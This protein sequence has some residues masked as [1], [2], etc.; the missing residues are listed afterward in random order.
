M[1]RRILPLDVFS[2]VWVGEHYIIRRCAQQVGAHRVDVAAEFLQD[3]G[4]V[5]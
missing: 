4:S 1:L 2:T 5:S 3:L